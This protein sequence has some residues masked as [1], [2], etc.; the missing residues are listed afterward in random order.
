MRQLG[1]SRG[2]DAPHWIELAG[3]V[4]SRDL[5]GLP[6][7][8]GRT[9]RPHRLIRSGHL[10]S[11]TPADVT[12]LVEE[13]GVRAVVDLRSE[14]EVRA[15][16]PGPLAAQPLVAIHALARAGSTAPHP[17]PAASGDQAPTGS[18]SQHPDGTSPYWPSPRSYLD[19]S[20]D[21]ILGALRLIARTDG[22]TI[23][24]C[25]AGKDRTGIVVALAL[26]EVGVDRDVIVADYVRSGEHIDAILAGLT[27]VEDLGLPIDAYLPRAETMI[28]LLA[29]LDDDYG[30]G[31]HRG[32]HNWLRRHGFTDA[33]GD[34]LRAKLLD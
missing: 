26:D 10:Q 31:T 23:V 1:Y 3:A 29:G 16:G 7:D 2:V 8:D 24:H 6:A 18:R 25:A 21:T 14:E 13:C 19:E 34:A 5:A 27:H 17:N 11:L 12:T 20:P 9:V 4:N 30:D 15:A 32:S 28:E 22:A 33:D